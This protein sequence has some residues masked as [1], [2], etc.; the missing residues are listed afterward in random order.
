METVTSCRRGHPWTP[1]NT[2]TRRDGSRECRTCSRA[3]Q[4]QW[5]KDKRAAERAA[6]PAKP[7]RETQ[8]CSVVDCKKSADARGMCNVHYQRWYRYGDASVRKRIHGDDEARFWSKVDKNGPIPEH[9]P[10]LGP[11]WLWTDA[12]GKHGYA[13][14]RIGGR[15]GKFVLVHRW[16]YENVVGPIPEGRQLDHICHTDFSRCLGG[17]TCLHR[18]CVNPAHLEPATARINTLRARTVS[19]ANAVKTHCKHGHAFD[20]ANTRWYRGNRYCRECGRIALRRYRAKIKEAGV[21]A[22]A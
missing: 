2:L 18:R 20:E 15:D 4:A 19:A 7:P 11:C 14:V 13:Q 16:A 21:T 3:R 5:A 6:R 10:E 12:P 8:P 1:E 17:D 9:R 22:T